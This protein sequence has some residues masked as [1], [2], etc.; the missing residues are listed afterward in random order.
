MAK[1]FPKRVESSDKGAGF[2]PVALEESNE[3]FVF[4]EIFNTTTSSTNTRDSVS[5]YAWIVSGEI[6]DSHLK[7]KP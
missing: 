1:K 4:S 6:K 2:T 5:Q 3:F 7:I